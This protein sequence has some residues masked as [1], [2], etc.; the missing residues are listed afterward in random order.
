MYDPK[1]ECEALI[2][3]ISELCKLKGYSYYAI[4]KKANISTSTMYSIMEGKTLPQLFT[5][6]NICNVLEIP[7][8]SIFESTAVHE[9]NTSNNL[10]P[11][12]AQSINLSSAE[13]HILQFYREISDKKRELLQIYIDMLRQYRE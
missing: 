3:R 13:K 2:S 4:A 7:I 8:A 9:D 12:D 6:F 11:P 10:K 5:L 1:F